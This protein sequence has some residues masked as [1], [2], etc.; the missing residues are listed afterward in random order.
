MNSLSQIFN[1]IAPLCLFVVVSVFLS[2]IALLCLGI[3]T[4][5]LLVL[6]KIKRYIKRRGDK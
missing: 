4:Y 1:Q 2:I 5:S 3:G 6:N